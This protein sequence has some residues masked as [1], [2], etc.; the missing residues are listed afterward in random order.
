VSVAAEPVAP[1]EP[2]T[3]ARMVHDLVDIDL[4]SGR[5]FA[6]G[7]PHD[8]FDA[9]RAA[10][11]VAWQ[12]EPP[13][14]PDLDRGELLRFVESPGFW[15]VTSHAL[16][17]EVLR[18]QSRFSSRLGSV[19]MPT[20]APESLVTFR[21]M[22]LNMDPPEHVRLRRI[23]VR[24]RD[25]ICLAHVTNAMATSGD[26]FEKGEADGALDALEVVAAIIERLRAD[27]QVDEMACQTAPASSTP[28]GDPSARSS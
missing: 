2:P 20:L 4:T 1:A 22:M 17:T 24:E 28:E 11:G 16:V 26:D 5:T 14:D 9:L 12:A 6:A 21:Q 13:L 23:L 27:G 3:G 7:V 10:G 25:V 15:V 18:D 8:A 19:F